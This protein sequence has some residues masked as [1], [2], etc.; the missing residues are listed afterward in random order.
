MKTRVVDMRKLNM[1]IGYGT[2]QNM[3]GKVLPKAS[4]FI[5]TATTKHLQKKSQNKSKTIRNV[6][7]LRKF[8][9]Y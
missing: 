6:L 1:L 7:T 5:L 8:K 9:F 3:E 4:G 2:R